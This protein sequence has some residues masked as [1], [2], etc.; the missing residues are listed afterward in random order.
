MDVPRFHI[1]YKLQ[2]IFYKSE[3]VKFPGGDISSGDTYVHS[4][5]KGG[6]TPLTLNL[7]TV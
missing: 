7:L 6:G 5:E 1:P 3:G 2:V 4:Q